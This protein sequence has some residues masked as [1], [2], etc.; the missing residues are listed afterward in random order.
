MTT[1]WHRSRR[2]TALLVAGAS[3]VVLAGCGADA[4]TGTAGSAGGE[5]VVGTLMPL[6]GPQEPLSNSY[7]S[8][9][10]YFDRVNKN[11]GIGGVKV[12]LVVRDD[13]FNPVNTPSKVR[14]L[15]DQEKARMLCANQG[16][17]TFKSIS[18]YLAAR[19]IPSLPMS[20]ESS[21]FTTGSTGFQLLTPYE[22][23]GAHLVRYGVETK[24]FT[25]VAI[26]Y[27]DDG[28]GGP[29]LSG[30]RQQLEAMGITPVAEVKINAAATDQTPAAAKLKQSRADLVVFN[31][32][33]PVVS[34]L[35]RATDRIGF[36]PHW[37]LTYAAQN[38]QVLELSGDALD[39]RATFA[40][41]FP[42]SEAPELADYRAAMESTDPKVDRTDFLTVE[43]WI[44]GAVCAQ[45]IETAVEEAGGVPS[46][47]QLL[48]AMKNTSVDTELVRGLTWS[49]EE[50]TGQRQLQLLGVSDGAFVPAQDYLP[51]PDVELGEG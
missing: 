35:V 10:A 32:V 41:P 18:S 38:K 49:Q 3:V 25:R 40:T 14:E 43:G 2:Y 15:V 23:T 12:R 19:K 34:Q 24:K 50:R 11:G 48:D 51:A 42:D 44:A 20:G 22:L 7:R 30:A 9:K 13:Q 16:S 39:D 36:R 27:T 47:T 33:A 1:P 17:G 37:G 6:S 31:H 45:V 29:F 26:A 28:V 8:M 5:L 4:E 21:L 46:S